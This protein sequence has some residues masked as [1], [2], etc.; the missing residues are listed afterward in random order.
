MRGYSAD[1]ATDRT[2]AVNADVGA[3]LFA[4]PRA[5]SLALW[6]HAFGDAATMRGFDP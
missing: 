5:G 2:V 1:V 3:R 6:L 4:I